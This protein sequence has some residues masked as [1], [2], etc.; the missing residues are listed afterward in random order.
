MTG[1][2]RHWVR[3]IAIEFAL[4]RLDLHIAK[5]HPKFGQPPQL[6]AVFHVQRRSNVMAI[7]FANI[8]VEVKTI[9]ITSHFDDGDLRDLRWELRVRNGCEQRI[10]SESNSF[11][12][13]DF[14]FAS[15]T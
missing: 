10:A 13:V 4:A 6:A 15:L 5:A 14:D 9:R 12:N 2:P 1:G 8:A 7:G 11:W 3:S